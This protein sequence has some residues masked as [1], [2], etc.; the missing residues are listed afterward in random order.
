MNKILI[1]GGYGNF[2]KKIALALIKQNISVIIAGR[3]R[4]K[5]ESFA[6]LLPPSLVNVAVFDINTEFTDQLKKLRPIVVINTCG[7]FQNTNYDIAHTCIVCG[8]HYIDLA[9]GRSFVTGIT[10]LD[11]SARIQNVTVISGASTVPGLSSAVIQ[12]YQNE[13]SEITSLIFGISLGQQI[14]RGLATTKA[15]FSYLGKQFEPFKGAT[16]AIYGWQ[17]NYIQ[18]YPEIGKRWMANC[19]IPDLD[20]LP[21]HY[22]ISSI[23]FSAGMELTLVH[24]GIW[25]LSWLVRLGM[26]FNP[27]NHAKL[28]LKISNWFNKFGTAKSGMHVILL[29]K[30]KQGKPLEKRWF[31]IAKDGDGIQIPCVPAI[32]IAKKLIS[33]SPLNP[34]AYPCVGLISLQDYM[35]E[36]KDFNIY[37]IEGNY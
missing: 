28:L 26:P 30:D 32:I 23:R 5:A 4:E 1:L 11:E 12:H 35:N 24:L 7:P 29:G 9:D 37:Q 16:K 14:E 3:N 22:N 18:N 25:L 36:L 17:D 27:S 6:S 13:F 31:I 15:I 19:D 10:K 33:D 34:G 2:G 8:V 21:A 20:L